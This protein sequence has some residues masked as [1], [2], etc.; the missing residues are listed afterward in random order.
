MKTSQATL[1]A[2]AALISGSALAADLPVLK[3]PPVLP[4]PPPLWTGFYFGANVGAIF[5]AGSGV[6]TTAFPL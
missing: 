6:T 1:A 4:P 5:D 2:V 3:A